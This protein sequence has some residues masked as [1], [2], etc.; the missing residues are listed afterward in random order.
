MPRLFQPYPAAGRRL[1]ELCSPIAIVFVLGC[2]L[3]S[4]WMSPAQGQRYRWH[5]EDFQYRRVVALPAGMET[6]PEVIVAE[7]FS[8]GAVKPEAGDMVV[9]ASKELVPRQVLQ[10][11]PGDFARVAFEPV[12]GE[13]RYYLYYGGPDNKQVNV[14]EWTS[15]SGLLF[16][17]RHWKNCDVNSLDSVRQAYASSTRIGSDY[18]GGVF[19]RHHPFAPDQ[20]PFLSRYVGT[21]NAPVKGEYHFYT[22]SQD[23]SFLLID[24]KLVVSAPGQHPPESRTRSKVSSPWK[25]V[26]IGSS[27]FMRRPV[28]RLAWWRPGNFPDW[29]GLP[30]LHRRCFVSIECSAFRQLNWSIATKVTCPITAWRFWVISR[31]VNLA[32]PQWFALSSSMHPRT[33]SS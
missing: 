18:V 13:S 33:P 5:D 20:G 9:Y 16:E 19:H 24:G 1:S 15:R 8:H 17:T 7:W 6:V 2:I 10:R 21:L 26:G 11:G 29:T 27:T 23:C 32:S 4:F 25:K 31:P 28:Q 3:S 30:R 22:S 14:P 12:A